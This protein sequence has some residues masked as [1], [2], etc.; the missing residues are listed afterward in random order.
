MCI[1]LLAGAGVSGIMSVI[2]TVVS[3]VGSLVGMMAQ[4]NAAKAAAN[5]DR[6]NAIIATRNAADA[7][8]R[9]VVAEQ[10]QQLKSKQIK[11]KQLAILSERAIGF[12]SGSSAIEILGDTAMFGKLDAL[13]TRGNYEREAISHETQK[14]NYLAQ[15]DINDMQ[16]SAAKFGAG[17]SLLSTG[18]DAVKDFRSM[19]L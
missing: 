19:R 1:P 18:V 6:N 4:A 10:E 7:R 13:T 5:Q 2:G 12:D 16:S 11:G 17:I 9:G 15:A 3:G 14:M 8:K